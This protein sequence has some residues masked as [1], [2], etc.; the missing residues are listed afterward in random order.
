MLGTPQQQ[1]A[2]MVN[3]ALSRIIPQ[4]PL[5]D[6][7]FFTWSSDVRAGLGSYYYSDYLESDNT[8]DEPGSFTHEVSRKCITAWIL[9]QMEKENRGGFEP[10]I[11]TYTETGPAIQDRPAKLWKEINDHHAA[12]SEELV[13]LAKQ[14]LNKITQL[15]GTPL[16]VHMHNFQQALN[17]FKALGGSLLE[18]EIGRKLLISLSSHYYR[19]A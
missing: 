18:N 19:D 10:K 12:R 7:N 11:T 13:L 14:A 3:Q 8:K 6:E 16:N 9:R 2:I 1:L 5:T 15:D 17:L 4:E